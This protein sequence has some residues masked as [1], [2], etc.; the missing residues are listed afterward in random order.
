MTIE[1]VKRK[2]VKFPKMT[3]EGYVERKGLYCPVC[4]S[5]QIE[6]SDISFDGGYMDQFMCCLACDATWY[7]YYKLAGYTALER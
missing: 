4:R 6:G 5:D 3:S 1:I 7:D 2:E